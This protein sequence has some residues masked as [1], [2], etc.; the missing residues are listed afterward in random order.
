M[1]DPGPAPSRI[2]VIISSNAPRYVDIA[3]KYHRFE[4]HSNAHIGFDVRKRLFDFEDYHSI[5]MKGRYHPAL[6]TVVQ[7]KS[8]TGAQQR[9]SDRT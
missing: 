7:T 8:S 9:K 4:L 6:H 1:C 3:S 5:G 2:A